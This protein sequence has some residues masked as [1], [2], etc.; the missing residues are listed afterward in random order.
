MNVRILPAALVVAGLA[1]CAPITHEGPQRRPPVQRCDDAVGDG[2]SVGRGHATALAIEGA[3]QQF[4]D[5]RGH[6]LALGYR[7]VRVVD[8][9]ITCKRHPVFTDLQKCT[10]A[11]RLCGR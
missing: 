4:A 5:A 10:A 9:K 11:A 3:R 8:H 2:L 7:H 6:L 1:A